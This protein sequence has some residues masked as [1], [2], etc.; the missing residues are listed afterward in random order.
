MGKGGTELLRRSALML[1]TLAALV[2]AA[3]AAAA[4]NLSVV[5]YSIPTSVYPKLISAYQAT[6]AGQ[7][8]QLPD[9]VRGV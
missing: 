7:G 3:A 1:V 4:T 8:H 6:P 2:A 9:L 5:G